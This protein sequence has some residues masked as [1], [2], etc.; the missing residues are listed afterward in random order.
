M[1]ADDLAAAVRAALAGKGPIRE[2][3]MFG[4]IGFMLNGNLLTGASK[5]SLLVRVG[6]DRED[7][8]LKRPGTRTMEMRG[9]KM[10]GYVYPPGLCASAVQGWMELASAFV[11][12]LPKKPASAKRAGA[13]AK[14]KGKRR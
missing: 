11:R 14:P 4:G 1:D 9:R 7:E 13:K 6:K 10:D 5:R 3:K 2:V 8:A 12:T